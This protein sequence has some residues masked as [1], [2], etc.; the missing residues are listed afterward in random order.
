[1]AQKTP[2]RKEEIKKPPAYPQVELLSD[3]RTYKTR[4]RHCNELFDLEEWADD[5][6]EKVRP[7]NPVKLTHPCG[8]VFKVIYDA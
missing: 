3:V 8:N 4:C 5:E 7:D 2:G 6:L 1:M